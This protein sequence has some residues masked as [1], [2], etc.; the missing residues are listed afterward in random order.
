MDIKKLSS[1]QKQKILFA[2]KERGIIGSTDTVEQRTFNKGENFAYLHKFPPNFS[3]TEFVAR[4]IPAT[5]SGKMVQVEVMAA[6]LNFRDLM[7]AMNM[8][9][10]TPGVP[11]VMGSDYAGIVVSVGNE[12]TKYKAG[13]RVM[14]LA[15]GSFNP[16][17]TIDQESHFAKYLNVS[18]NQVFFMSENLSFTDA[19]GV[20]TVFITAYYAL[21][22]IARIKE[23]ETVLIHSA[24]G[25][26]GMAAIELCKYVGCKIFATA[27]NNRKREILRSM[28]IAL[29]MDSRSTEFSSQVMEY[30]KNKGVNVILNT[31]SGE[32]VVEGIS[33]LDFFGRFLDI[34]KKDIAANVSLPL[35][36]FNKGLTFS[37]I[38]LALLVKNETL[39]GEIFYSLNK[40]FSEEKIHPV[41]TKIYPYHKL[42][43]ALNYMSRS[44]HVGKLV[45]DY[46]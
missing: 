32:S 11:S 38:D 8:Y 14:V 34:D 35:G 42:G 21:M 19:A 46:G 44:K 1:E 16:D 39:L 20:P 31:L 36:N 6:S 4:P 37:A 12:V 13:D 27:G 18:E 41:Q 9:P 7:M 10:S 22:S 5:P 29:V 23:G 40:L 30:T 3:R 28:G 24:T 15:A 2:L 43:E 45:L 33:I 26:V 25:G 17:Y